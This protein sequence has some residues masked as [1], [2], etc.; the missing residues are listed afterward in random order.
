MSKHKAK[1]KNYFFSFLRFFGEQ[2]RNTGLKNFSQFWDTYLKKK[3][4]QKKPHTHTHRDEI[5]IRALIPT[6]DQCVKLLKDYFALKIEKTNPPYF[7]DSGKIHFNHSNLC[8]LM[9]HG[10][11]ITQHTLKTQKTFCERLY[12]VFFV[13]FFFTFL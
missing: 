1:Y 13:C 7:K 3:T 4:M 12:F 11:Y 10:T 9:S 2:N 8:Y 6:N 5:E